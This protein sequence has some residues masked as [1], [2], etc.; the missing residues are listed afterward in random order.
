MSV[1]IEIADAVVAALNAACLSQSVTARRIYVAPQDLADLADL[2]VTVAPVELAVIASDL[3]PRHAWQPQVAVTVRKRVG[4]S[5]E[6]AD[7]LMCL[8]EEIIQ[9]FGTLPLAGTLARNTA[10]DVRLI[11]SAMFDARGVMSIL[12]ILTF[13]LII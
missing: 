5:M 6:Q 9:L 3:G 1:V 2:D 7:A 10:V 11:D 8:A 12:I 4:D 13:R